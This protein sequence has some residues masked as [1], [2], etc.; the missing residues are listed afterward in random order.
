MGDVTIGAAELR[1]LATAAFRRAGLGE[2]DAALAAEGLV[3]T[4][5]MGIGTHGVTRLDT[6]CA[7]VARGTIKGDATIT[8]ERT[9]PSLAA[10]D[11]GHGLGVVVGA[12]AMDEA[13][14]LAEQTGIGFVA[15]RDSSHFGAA[16]LYALRAA[17]QDMIGLAV[18]NASPAMAPF[19][20]RDLIMGNNPF[21]IGA[22]RRDAFPLILDMALSIAARGKM[23]RLRDAGQ[24][25]PTGWALD[26]DG[27]PTT[28]PAAGLDGFIQFVGDHKGYGLAVMMDLLAG[29]LSGGAFLTGSLGMWQDEA[30]MRTSHAFLALDPGKL[31]PRAAY[32]ERVEAFC[33][34]I[35]GCRPFAEDGEVLLPG[36]LEG[37]AH[38]RQS[39]EGIRL[40]EKTLETVRRLAAGG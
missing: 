32:E 28:D 2:A 37:R 21:A 11:G 38:A 26:R 13:V 8:V 5:L 23:R 16:G 27:R 9:A 20:G 12:R 7:L 40:Q 4:D 1:A 3:E 31:M 22:P 30:P 24:E 6:Y 39:A 10:V 36:E 33:A 17:R 25:M 15:V 29:V 34:E 35:K 18:T 19:G 14:A